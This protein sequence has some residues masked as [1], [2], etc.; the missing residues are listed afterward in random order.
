[1]NTS[2]IE[3]LEPRLAPAGLIAV[4]VTAAGTLTLGTVAGQDGDETVVISRLED[5]GY[6]LAPV[7]GVI[8]RLNGQNYTTPQTVYGVTGLTANLGA[9]ND[10]ILLNS[11]YFGK[12][13]SVNLG[14]GSNGFLAS[15]SIF[16]STF[17]YTGGDGQDQLV[18]QDDIFSV[19]G[20][21]TLKL[22][23]GNDSIICSVQ[24]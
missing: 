21:T 12:A 6:Q 8:L 17:M 16:G 23:G 20:A 3:S 11:C 13:V 10:S 18:F 19:S 1:M 7:A 14:Q 4:S 5:G 15:D 2:C 24:E 22:G 9:G